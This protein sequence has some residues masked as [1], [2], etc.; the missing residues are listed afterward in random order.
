MQR[1][2]HWHIDP[3]TEKQVSLAFQRNKQTN[4]TEQVS[5][6]VQSLEIYNVASINGDGKGN[7]TV[8]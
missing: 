7:G 8:A 2:L 5:W 1:I 4:S 3:I 6:L